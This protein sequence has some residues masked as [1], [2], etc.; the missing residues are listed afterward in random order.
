MKTI[1]VVLLTGIS[2]TGIIRAEAPMLS[3]SKVFSFAAA[4]QRKMAN[5]GEA[6]DMLIGTLK[7]GETVRLHESMQPEG[8]SPNPAHAI[9]HSEFIVVQEGRLAFLHDGVVEEAGPGDV[10]Y[11]AFGTMHQV[12]NIGKSPAKYAVVSIGGDI[13]P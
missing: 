6:R 13:K 7:S 1:V 4:P 3:H 12:K 8:A 2:V 9:E 10:V 5:G 11:V